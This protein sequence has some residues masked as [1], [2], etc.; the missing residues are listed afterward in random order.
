MFESDTIK[1]ALERNFQKYV[2]NGFENMTKE[3]FLDLMAHTIFTSLE[4]YK[5]HLAKQNK[6]RLD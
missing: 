1:L 2:K 6:I 4:K 5:E 3:E